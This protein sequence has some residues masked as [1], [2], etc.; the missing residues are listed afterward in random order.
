MI[1][2]RC[3]TCRNV[4]EIRPDVPAGLI[5]IPCGNRLISFDQDVDMICVKCGRKEEVAANKKVSAHHNSD[6]RVYI[7]RPKKKEAL[8]SFRKPEPV[9]EIV[10]EPEIEVEVEEKNILKKR[11]IS[12]SKK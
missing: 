1:K 10:E 8:K 9:E 5:C 3:E 6:H 4:I 2:V 7:I 11:R 12:R